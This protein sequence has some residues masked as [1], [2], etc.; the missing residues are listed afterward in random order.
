MNQILRSQTRVL[1]LVPTR[2]VKRMKRAQRR[3]LLRSVSLWPCGILTTVIQND[4]QER[5]WPDMG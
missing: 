5:N 3:N 2:I 1:V 4:V